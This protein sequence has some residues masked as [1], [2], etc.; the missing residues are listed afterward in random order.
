MVLGIIELHYF[1]PVN[2]LK[3]LVYLFGRLVGDVFYQY[4]GCPIGGELF[5]HN[6]KPS[7]GVGVFGEVFGDVIVDGN[8]WD[9]DNAVDNA[10]DK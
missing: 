5:L 1:D 7:T 4:V 8:F 9:A 6:G 2:G 10:D 3:L